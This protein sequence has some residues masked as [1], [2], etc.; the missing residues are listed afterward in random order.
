MNDSI[1]ILLVDDEPRFSESLAQIL[2]L[3]GYPVTIA[4]RG[5]EA[6]G[7]LE[8]YTFDLLLLDVE[9]PDMLGYRSEERRVGK[10]C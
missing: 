6:V 5:D 10:E 2:T 7:L 9:L 1:R 8:R 3:S 4:E